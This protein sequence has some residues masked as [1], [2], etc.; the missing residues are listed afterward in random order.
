[1]VISPQVRAL[2]AGDTKTDYCVPFGVHLYGTMTGVPEIAIVLG[3]GRQIAL[4]YDAQLTTPWSGSR[5]L[6]EYDPRSE[7]WRNTPPVYSFTLIASYA[8]ER[9]VL[10]VGQDIAAFRCAFQANGATVSQQLVTK[11]PYTTQCT[12]KASA[13][14]PY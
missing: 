12:L 1:M 4:P 14:N 7:R 6:L 8:A 5:L 11:S 2:K 10:Y 9:D 3:G 13:F